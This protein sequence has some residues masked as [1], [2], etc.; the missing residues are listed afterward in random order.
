MNEFYLGKVSIPRSV[1]HAKKIRDSLA[2]WG[3]DRLLHI[4]R[5]CEGDDDKYREE[6]GRIHNRYANMTFLIPEAVP[7]KSLAYTA[8]TLLHWLQEDFE[9]ASTGAQKD[10]AGICGAEL[11]KILSLYS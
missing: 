2:A 5:A 10:A 4:V 1:K 11:F 6:F 3:T 7:D 9:Y 8:E